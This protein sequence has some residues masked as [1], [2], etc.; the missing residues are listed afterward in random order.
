MLLKLLSRRE[1]KFAFSA[2]CDIIILK[3]EMFDEENVWVFVSNFFIG[4]SGVSVS[5]CGSE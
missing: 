3:G 5:G 1:N 4:S 2:R